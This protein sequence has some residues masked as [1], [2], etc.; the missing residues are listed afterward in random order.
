MQ[1]VSLVHFRENVKGDQMTFDYKLREGPVLAGNALRLMRLIGL[2]VPLESSEAEQAAP[3][4]D[5]NA[6]ARPH[7]LRK[8]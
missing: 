8:L 7:G 4:D 6:K 2:G 3:A 5:S 1:R